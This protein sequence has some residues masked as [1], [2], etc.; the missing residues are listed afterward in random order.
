[1]SREGKTKL[2]HNWI[3]HTIFTQFA[4]VYNRKKIIYFS[5]FPFQPLSISSFEWFFHIFVVTVSLLNAVVVDGDE[6]G[7]WWSRWCGCGDVIVVCGC[8][9]VVTIQTLC[10]FHTFSEFRK[11]SICIQSATNKVRT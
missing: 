1:M 10:T 6:D 11:I 2:T 3:Y 7:W 9:L 5:T 4:I 8:F